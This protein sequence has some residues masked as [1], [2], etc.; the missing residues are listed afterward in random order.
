MK[1]TF[2]IFLRQFTSPA[3]LILLV[4]AII[5]GLVGNVHDALILLAIIVPSGLLTFIQEFRAENT[6]RAL[7]K[8]LELRIE[9]V[10]DGQVIEIS[11]LD[12]ELGDVIHINPGDV[13]PADL[14]VITSENLSIDES[15]LTGEAFPK[16]K[17]E[18]GDYELFMG[19]YA[20]SG[21][22]TAKV[23]RVGAKTKYGVM[24][25]GLSKV[26]IETTFERGIRGFGLLV[27]RAILVLV[28]FVFFGNIAL[29]R[30][31]FNS[32][33][34]SLALAIGLTPQMLP[35]IISVCLSA[36]AR[37][38]A[39]EKVLIRRLDAI[40]DLGTLE[41]LCTDKT[42]TLTTGELVVSGAIDAGGNANLRVLELAYENALLQESSANFVDLALVKTGVVATPR[43][44]AK[45]I[46]FSFERRCVSIQLEDGELISK[47]AFREILTFCTLVRVGNELRAKELEIENLEQLYREKAAQGFK[48][49]AVASKEGDTEIEMN[50]EGFILIE[51]PAKKGVTESL[52]ELSR[53]GIDVV[54]ISG[55]S[56]ESARHI[57][58]VVGIGS[59]ECLTGK[60]LDG[61]SD[62][63][64][65]K[66][67]SSA[68]VFAEVDPIQ[69]ARIVTALKAS[70][71]SIGFLGDG[72][73]DALALKNADVS[74]S[75]DDA[76]D[77]AKSSSSI[78]LLEKDLAVIADGVRVGRR[79]FENTMKYI[80]ITISASFGNVLS[81]A[82]ASFF[83]PFL[84]MLPTQ[85]LLLNFLSDLPA[86]AISSD[87]VDRED[88]ERPA[89]WSMR[90][91][92][93]FMVFFGLIS[94]IFDL[95]LFLLSIAWLEGSK[96]ELRSSWFAA[97]LITEVIAILVLRTKRASW[98]SQPSRTLFLISL[99]VVVIA[100]LIPLTGILAQVG[101]PSVSTPYLLTVFAL[102][103]LY[104]FAIE[105]AKV[106][107]KLMRREALWV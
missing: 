40:E 25:A 70:G 85:I 49:I 15:V 3:I 57:S 56:A 95:T 84:P 106:R 50:F 72:I 90:G 23:V 87:K 67:L 58:E 88:L 36:G 41:I 43:K 60:E 6:L 54:L 103:T 89:H 105:A 20:V 78:V 46:D 33:L 59:G 82:I 63:E 68:R 8:R 28:V 35:V 1:S 93:H 26:D 97:S 37:H 77:V 102:T 12:L 18:K 2:R 62:T 86:I 17:S 66:S 94:T 53:L 47:G 80:R 22:S 24:E 39:D 74:I 79:T 48:I 30:P 61:L 71:K 42:G 11:A 29:D 101:L 51:D 83:L 13:I 45:E 7:Q 34:F 81:M 16:R 38:L 5:Y 44:K 75:V 65:S 91:I 31:T 96:G 69:K 9:V 55:D 98:A 92:G 14:E 32:L 21:S 104:W 73:N 64:L 19:T 4:S 107:P 99:V 27:A 76:V 100:W 10:R 52:K